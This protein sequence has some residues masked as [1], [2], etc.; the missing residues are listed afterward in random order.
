MSSR[1]PPAH[2]L[3]PAEPLATGSAPKAV[4]GR[5][6]WRGVRTLG[7]FATGELKLRVGA[8]VE[9]NGKYYLDENALRAMK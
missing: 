9:V 6:G 3:P 7:H 1:R 4:D 2:L 5:R 8:F